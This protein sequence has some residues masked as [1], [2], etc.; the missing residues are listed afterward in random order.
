MALKY[1]SRLASESLDGISQ[2]SRFPKPIRRTAI[3]PSS[4][5]KESNPWHTTGGHCARTSKSLDCSVFAQN[6]RSVCSHELYC[7]LGVCLCLG[8]T[9]RAGRHWDRPWQILPSRWR[10]PHTSTL[11]YHFANSESQCAKH[12]PPLRDFSQKRIQLLCHCKIT[13]IWHC[14]AKANLAREDPAAR[15]RKGSCLYL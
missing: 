4:P 7:I 15:L 12:R 2:T 9:V 11:R 13:H 3:F 6:L 10:I 8:R 1:S 5:K 14:D